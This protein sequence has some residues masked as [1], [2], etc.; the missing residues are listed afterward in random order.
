VICRGVSASCPR[1]RLRCTNKATLN[2]RFDRWEPG[3]RY[4]VVELGPDPQLDQFGYQ[5]AHPTGPRP[6]FKAMPQ[7]DWLAQSKRD[8]GKR[9]QGKRDRQ[10]RERRRE[11][12][13]RGKAAGVRLGT[14]HCRDF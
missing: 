1:D 6:G 13:G 4:F 12:E 11:A 7:R 10:A 9:D 8:Q 5:S 3:S 2:E 14:T